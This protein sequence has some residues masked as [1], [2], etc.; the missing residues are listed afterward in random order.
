MAS[1]DIVSSSVDNNSATVT[2]ITYSIRSVD[3]YTSDGVLVFSKQLPPNS[4]RA[5]IDVSGLRKGI[6]YL[7]VSDGSSNT[8]AHRVVIN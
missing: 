8:D 4:K 6:Y 5:D 7:H 2:P 3:L 1:A